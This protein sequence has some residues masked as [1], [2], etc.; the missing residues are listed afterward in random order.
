M[1]NIDDGWTNTNLAMFDK[2]KVGELRDGEGSVFKRKL[3]KKRKDSAFTFRFFS[4][5]LFVGEHFK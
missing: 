4:I 5:N 2:Y 3:L 1:R